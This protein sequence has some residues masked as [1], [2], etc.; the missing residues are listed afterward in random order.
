[1]RPLH[2]LRRSLES[3]TFF[4]INLEVEVT[5]RIESN[6]QLFELKL[7]LNR[8][9]YLPQKL[10][11]QVHLLARPE[12]LTL[13][14]K[15]VPIDQLAKSLELSLLTGSLHFVALCD[16]SFTNVNID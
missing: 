14:L 9:L 11:N 15:V 3:R 12:L 4:L 1:M 8:R 6:S 5:A 2:R 13:R 10:W 16:H 7:N